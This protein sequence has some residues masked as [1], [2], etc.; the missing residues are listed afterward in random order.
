MPWQGHDDTEERSTVGKL[1]NSNQHRGHHEGHYRLRKDGRWECQFTLPDGK[2]KSVYGK[3]RS[4]V[5]TKMV[6]ALGKAKKGID[7][8]GERQTLNHYLAT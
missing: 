2:V 6:E 7:L 5:R 8:K 1:V 3:T 4:E